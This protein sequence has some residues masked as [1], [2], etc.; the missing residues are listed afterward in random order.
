MHKWGQFVVYRYKQTKSASRKFK[1]DVRTI[2]SQFLVVQQCIIHSIFPVLRIEKCE[3]MM[4][5]RGRFVVPVR[6][7]AN[8]KHM[9]KIHKRHTI[10]F[11]L[12]SNTWCIQYFLHWESISVSVRCHCNTDHKAFQASSTLLSVQMVMRGA[13]S[14]IAVEDGKITSSD[15]IKPYNTA[16]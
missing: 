10:S 9:T 7:Q 15:W 4:Y 5:K 13:V 12:C 11:L 3:C 14:F 16:Q 6:V 2:L 1:K 8:K